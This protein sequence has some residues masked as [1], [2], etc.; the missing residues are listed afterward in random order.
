MNE[1]LTPR[2][3]VSEENEGQSIDCKAL[4][5]SIDN[6]ETRGKKPGLNFVPA[7][8]AIQNRRVLSGVNGRKGYVGGYSRN[9]RNARNWS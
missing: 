3:S 8:A 2:Q 7:V 4:S 6:D 9:L 5:A 1:S